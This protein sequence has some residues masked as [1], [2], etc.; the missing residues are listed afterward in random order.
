MIAATVMAAD[1][2]AP[3]GLGALSEYQILDSYVTA[4]SGRGM[5]FSD[6]QLMAATPWF[7]NAMMR[8][9]L[10]FDAVARAVCH[11]G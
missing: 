6:P 2:T 4:G 10:S 3:A 11:R 1:L 5:G 7:A 8:N 9:C